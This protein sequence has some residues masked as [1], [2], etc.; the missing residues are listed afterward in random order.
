L[1]DKRGTLLRSIRRSADRL[2]RLAADLTTSPLLYGETVQLRL[3]Q[4]SLNQIL[5]DGATRA[6]AADSAVQLV[7]DVPY[8]AVLHADAGRLAQALDN[9]LDNA[10]RHGTPPIRLSGVVDDQI[11]IRVSDAGPG[12]PDGL[13]PRLFERFAMAG[14][15]AGTGLGLY[16]VREIARAHGGEAEYRPPTTGEPAAFEIRLP[17]T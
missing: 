6:L 10:V 4:T 16:L 7:L 8:D 13:V 2:R 12:I 1:A 9:L 11:H 17:R 5:R 15:S 14:A 3:E